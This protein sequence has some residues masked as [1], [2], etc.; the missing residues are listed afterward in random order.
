M[1]A[2]T[3]QTVENIA[4]QTHVIHTEIVKQTDL[5]QTRLA[6]VFD[7]LKTLHVKESNTKNSHSAQ[8]RNLSS[9]T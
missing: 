1:T 6:N 3:N 7:S 8:R 2:D 5:M 9:V 4:D